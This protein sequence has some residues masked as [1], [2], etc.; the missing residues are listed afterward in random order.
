MATK[1]RKDRNRRS[2]FCVLLWPLFFVGSTRAQ[3]Q[4]TPHL[5]YAYP[6]GGR[7]GSTFQVKVGGQFLDGL[8][9]CYITG[10]GVRAAVV[11]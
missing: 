5:G 8:T 6:A 1:E 2:F 9:N 7:Q 3:Q 10:V 11:E 4:T